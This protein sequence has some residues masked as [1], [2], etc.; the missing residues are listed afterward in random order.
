[1]RKHRLEDA[2]CA[3]CMDSLFDQRDDLDDEVP[4]ATCDCGHVFHE[5]CLLEWFRT[6]SIQYLNAAR[7]QGV[8]GRH[9]SPSLSDAPAECPSCRTECFADPETGEPTIH[10]LYI[11]FGNAA[12]SSSQ[13]GSSP[14][15]SKSW[16][17]KEREFLGLARRAKGVA[18]GVRGL[19]GES[20]EEHMEGMLRRAEG[21]AD[22]LVSVK[23]LNGI[24]KYVGG[25]TS[26]INNLK[27]ALQT[28]PLIRGLVAKNAQLEADINDLKRRMDSALRREIKKAVDA[29]RARADANVRKAQEECEV[30]RRALDKEQ[31][32]RRSGRKAMEER[33]QEYERSLNAAKEELRR[34][35]EDRER[36][37]GDL[38]ERM[39]QIRVLKSKE[40]SRRTLKAELKQLESENAKL[41]SEA[42]KSNALHASSSRRAS[43]IGSEP[44]HD[45]SAADISVQEISGT[46]FP[47]YRSSGKQHDTNNTQDDSLQVDMPSFRD[48]SLRSLSRLLPRTTYGH[49]SM[50]PSKRA[51]PSR[52]HPTVRT[53]QFDLEEGLGKKRKSSKYFSSSDKENVTAGSPV[54]DEWAE[55]IVGE[56]PSPPKRS[57]TNPF[58]TTRKESEK[59]KALPTV[60]TGSAVII[61]ASSP[62]PLQRSPRRQPAEVIDLASPSPPS[63]PARDK[64]RKREKVWG[65]LRAQGSVVE[66]LGVR[67]TNGRP[68]KN[69][70]I[71][72]KVKRRV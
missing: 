38:Q 72:Q 7:D 19:G 24:K 62:P 25:L 43:S 65:E 13:A 8:Q 23:A 58:A 40:E 29:E 49:S 56:T 12:A 57:K 42:G 14:V 32:A 18:E 2:S 53:I 71:G 5:P 64:E 31:V 34:E 68:K 36:M 60:A 50:S 41:K 70:M 55:V 66:W 48:D 45:T 35:R 21:L 30:M 54:D 4:I 39:K 27:T 10:R 11:D 9:G 51:G 46:S 20:E 47:R 22:D 52:A 69:V 44:D 67:D 37:Q 63:T 26:S 16:K 28:H 3:I 1:M 33:A 61:P 17:G 59:R 6:Q 15:V